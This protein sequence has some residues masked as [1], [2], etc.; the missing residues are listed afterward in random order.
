MAIRY[1][2]SDQQVF[3]GCKGYPECNGLLPGDAEPKKEDVEKAAY[4]KTPITRLAGQ[5]KTY[6]TSKPSD[7]DGPIDGQ[8][9]PF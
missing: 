2:K 6:E 8:D 3:F 7:F 5:P 1:R 9:A 4:L